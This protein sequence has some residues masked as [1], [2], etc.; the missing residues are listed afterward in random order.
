MRLARLLILSLVVSFLFSD[1]LPEGREKFVIYYNDFEES[2]KTRINPLGIEEI[3]SPDSL[4]NGLFGKGYLCS[5]GKSFVLRSTQISPHR[6]LTISIW[7]A[8]KEEH[9]PGAGFIIFSL[10]GKGFISCFVRG[11]NGDTWCALTKPAGVF[12]VYYFPGIQNI[13]GIYDFDIMK[14]L[15]LR[16][17]IWHNTI[18]TFSCGREVNV[19]QDGRR[20]GRWILTRCLREDDGINSLTLAPYGEAMFF[21]EVLI[22]R[23]VL[24]EKEVREYYLKVKGLRDIFGDWANE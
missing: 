24:G 17:G 1:I 2:G 5:E 16:G 8:L 4:A 23:G 9:K 22:M 19:Y 12:Q 14:T 20:V 7:W 21:D 13:N 3:F 18:V 6:S 15:D 10:N 11:G